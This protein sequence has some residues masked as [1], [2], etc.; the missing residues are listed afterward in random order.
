VT[1]P[2]IICHGLTGEDATQLVRG[3][4][5]VPVKGGLKITPLGRSRVSGQLAL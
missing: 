3:A 2:D 5:R 4:V 1:K